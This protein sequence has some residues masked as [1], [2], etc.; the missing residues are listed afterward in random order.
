MNKEHAWTIVFGH[1]D[2]TKPRDNE[3]LFVDLGVHN[4]ADVLRNKRLKIRFSST[5]DHGLLSENSITLAD[6]VIMVTLD[7]SS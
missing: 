1:S 4:A 6:K 2:E 5:A 7:L 3:V